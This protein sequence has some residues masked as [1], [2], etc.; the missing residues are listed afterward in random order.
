MSLLKEF[1]EWRVLLKSTVP[2]EYGDLKRRLT[3]V[4]VV[5]CKRCKSCCKYVLI[6]NKALSL[7][8]FIFVAICVVWTS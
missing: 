7:I 3:I 8:I 6:Y 5:F 4:S 1:H 2:V